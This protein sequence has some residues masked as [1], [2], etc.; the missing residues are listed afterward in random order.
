MSQRVIVKVKPWREDSF[1][2]YHHRSDYPGHSSFSSLPLSS[3]LNRSGR[4]VY[5]GCRRREQGQET[6]NCFPIPKNH[7]EDQDETGR[8]RKNLAGR[9]VKKP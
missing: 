8:N 9:I 2:P 4:G 6:G 1:D 7:D 5:I 3:V